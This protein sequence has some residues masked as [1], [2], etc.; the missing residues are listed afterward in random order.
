MNTII[1]FFQFLGLVLGLVFVLIYVVLIIKKFFMFLIGTKDIVDE[2]KIINSKL[3][4]LND[5]N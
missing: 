1:N 5:E 4:R 2:L 3:K